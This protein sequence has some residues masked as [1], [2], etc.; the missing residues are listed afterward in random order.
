[1][2]II[3]MLYFIDTYGVF[4]HCVEDVQCNIELSSVGVVRCMNALIMGDEQYLK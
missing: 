4:L 3:I 2:I 1:M